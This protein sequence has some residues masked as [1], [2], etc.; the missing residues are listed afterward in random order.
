MMLELSRTEAD[1]QPVR[2]PFKKPA[3]IDSSAPDYV[4]LSERYLTQAFFIHVMYEITVVGL[5]G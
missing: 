3:Q 1:S 5:T 4:L 2:F